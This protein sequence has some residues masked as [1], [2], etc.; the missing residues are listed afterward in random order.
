MPAHARNRP[1][2]PGESPLGLTCAQYLAAARGVDRAVRPD[3]DAY[4]TFMR[5]GQ[6]DAGRCIFQAG[7]A[8]QVTV[9]ES[10][11]GQVRKFL[12]GVPRS[13][14]EGPTG[15]VA[16]GDDLQTESVII[17]MIG[18]RGER[19]HTLCVSS[20]V[21]CAMGC[22]FCETAQMGL[23][24]SLSPAE[25]VNQYWT[26]RHELGA[27]IR[28]IVFMGMG[29]P[30]DNLDRVLQA[31]EVLRDHRGIAFPVSKIVISTVGRIDGLRR[32]AE[33]VREPGW[34]RLNLAVSLNASD[35]ATRSSLM[36]VN[37][38]MPMEALREELVRW[39]LFG[40]NKICFEY[41]LIPGVNDS[42]ADAERI[43]AFLR[44]FAGPPRTAMV[45]VIPYNP[46]RG[47]PWP[48]PTEE[49][50]HSFLGW[51]L[52]RDVYCKRRRTKGRD[53]MGACGQLGNERIRARRLV[54]LS[55]DGTTA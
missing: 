41:V 20:Q 45:N 36:P 48:A 5:L 40:G 46:R 12:L 8:L 29:E 24:R 1:A 37:R 10:A 9:S 7:G 2:W 26:A 53:M 27:D 4:A 35:D 13:V 54:G 52:D 23:I 33:K 42:R 15:P 19:T 38:G 34:H 43:G 21:G 30:L 32:L 14:P 16:A 18:R 47:S 3:P 11:E 31:I 25:I 49:S 55:I 44:P 51:L 50:I 28:N 39:P 6:V 22:A 17:P